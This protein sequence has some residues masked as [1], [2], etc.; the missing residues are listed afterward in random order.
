MNKMKFGNVALYCKGWYAHRDGNDIPNMWMD[1]AHCIHADGWTV[2]SKKDVA[3]WCMN[4]FDDWKDVLHLDFHKLWE[5]INDHRRQWDW[6]HDDKLSIEDAVIWTMHG[7]IACADRDKFDGAPFMPDERVLP[8]KYEHAYYYPGISEEYHFAAMHCDVEEDIKKMFPD[9]VKQTRK[10]GS[11]VRDDSFDYI[12]SILIGKSWK[13]VLVKNG[14]DS[15]IDC[16]EFIVTGKFFKNSGNEPL[17]VEQEHV[18]DDGSISKNFEQYLRL[19]IYDGCKDFDLDKEYII[20][21]KKDDYGYILKSI[22]EA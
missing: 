9:G 11:W 20:R 10:N 15:L 2:F 5:G 19:G 4:R 6:H 1:L 14:S 13:K 18:W 3:T 12:E 22:K 8:L 21:A 7:L 17:V 16:E